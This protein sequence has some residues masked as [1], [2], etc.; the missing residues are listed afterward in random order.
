MKWC[1]GQPGFGPQAAGRVGPGTSHAT[2]G[3]LSAQYESTMA[4]KDEVKGRV[5][6]AVAFRVCV[7]VSPPS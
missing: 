5:V 3:R 2:V 6:D 1:R 7:F 4:C